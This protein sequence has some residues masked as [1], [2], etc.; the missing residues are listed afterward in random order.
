MASDEKVIVQSFTV[1]DGQN[2]KPAPRKGTA[3]AIRRAN[4]VAIEG[5]AEQVDISL[6]DGN[7]FI[8]T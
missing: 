8:R 6:L 3:D 5:T 1:W 2:N 4:G 7:G